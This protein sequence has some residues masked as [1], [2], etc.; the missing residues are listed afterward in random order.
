MFFIFAVFQWK[1]GCMICKFTF[2]YVDI[3]FGYIVLVSIVVARK[4]FCLFTILAVL[5]QVTH[6][7]AWMA[8]ML[9]LVNWTGSWEEKISANPCSGETLLWYQNE[10][11]VSLNFSL[12]FHCVV[13]HNV[14]SM[15]LGS[16][17]YFGFFA[18]VVQT[19]LFQN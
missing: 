12:T 5:K 11:N 18:L 19:T 7:F 16:A 14:E 17:E 6:V 8:Y 15:S 9:S 3:V 10:H 13:Y 4:H 1:F 2:F